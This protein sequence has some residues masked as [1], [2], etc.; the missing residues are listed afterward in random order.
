M[1][2]V[3]RAPARITWASGDNDGDKGG[4]AAAAADDD[5]DDDDHD[6]DDDDDG[7]EITPGNI[8]I[9]KRGSPHGPA[10]CLG[11][12][13]WSCVAQPLLSQAADSKLGKPGAESSS[14]SLPTG[15]LPTALRLKHASDK[16]TFSLMLA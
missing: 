14:A 4:D 11:H 1:V 3:T 2:Q 5:D 9:V 15:I 16:L 6:D 7:E 8:V 13:D 12:L 10:C